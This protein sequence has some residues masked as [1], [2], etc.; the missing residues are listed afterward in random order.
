MSPNGITPP[1]VIAR[2]CA[3]ILATMGARSPIRGDA[4]RITTISSRSS[5]KNNA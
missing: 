4:K 2:E 1:R 3:D 5:C